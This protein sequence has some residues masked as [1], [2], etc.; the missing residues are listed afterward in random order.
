MKTKRRAS[1]AIALVAILLA[2]PLAFSL[3]IIDIPNLPFTS[4]PTSSTET[5]SATT[6]VFVDLDKIIK[7][8]QPGPGYQIG[9][10]LQ[11]HLNITD[12]TDLYTYNINI[13]WNLTM[14]NFTRIVSYG[15]FL[16]QTASPY[17]TSRITDITNANNE[18][19]YA[20][21]AES[22]LGNYLGIHGNGRLVTIEFHIVGYGSID[23]TI[24]LQGT[25]PTKLLN[26]TGNSTT[27]TT[28]NGY[29]RNT[30]PSDVNEDGAVNVLD[31]GI[32]SANWG[33]TIP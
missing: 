18:T 15:N 21:I 33:R 12:A 7:N 31:I 29:F 8:Y 19:G 4:T 30:I 26:S 20:A 28:T 2:I 3:G 10:T 24:S 25:L 5:A 13:T 17:G 6:T 32:T 9:D 27:F 16:A 22:I 1:L 23:L 11:I 14:L